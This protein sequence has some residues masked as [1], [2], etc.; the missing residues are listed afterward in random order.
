[1]KYALTATLLAYA[2]MQSY[3]ICRYGMMSIL[4][5]GLHMK[6]YGKLVRDKIPAIIEQS[7]G[8]PTFHV[9]N[10]DAAY[11]QALC[12]KLIEEANEVHETPVLEELAD[13]L[14][15]VF[16][17]GKALGYTSIQIEEARQQKA[18]QRGGFE[19]RI[20]LEKTSPKSLL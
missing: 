8:A 4:S 6:K 14:E 17:T 7:G 2:K 12:D 16:A 9:I 18:D 15:V 19:E 11:L 5:R 20:F 3:I 10:D 13:V 1:M